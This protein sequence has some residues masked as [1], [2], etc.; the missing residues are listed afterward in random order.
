MADFIGALQCK[1]FRI[2]QA[3]RGPN[4]VWC[5][6]TC[7]TIRRGRVCPLVRP[8]ELD[9]TAAELKQYEQRI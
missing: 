9:E 2:S 4:V 7:H 3:K 1:W 5:C 6:S 8:K